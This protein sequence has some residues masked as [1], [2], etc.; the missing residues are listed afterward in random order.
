MT[1]TSLYFTAYGLW[2]MTVDTAVKCMSI[3]NVH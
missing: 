2:L 1:P 3:Y